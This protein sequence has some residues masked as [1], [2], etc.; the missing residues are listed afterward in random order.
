MTSYKEDYKVENA[1]IDSTQLGVPCSG[2]GILSFVIGL[3]YGG[4]GQGFGTLILDSYDETKKERIPTPLAASL[5]LGI[6]NLFGVDWE[7]LKDSSCRSY[8]TSMHVAAIGHFLKDK[9]LWFDKSIMEFRVTP[10]ADI[11]LDG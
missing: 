6:N 2:H 9:W 4:R 7:D 11:K 8:H 5:L 1:T 10:F 3:D